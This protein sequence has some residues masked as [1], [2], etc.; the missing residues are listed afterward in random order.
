MSAL[1]GLAA[2]VGN[3]SGT[4]MLQDPRTGTAAES[5]STVSIMP[6]MGDRFFRIDYT[7]VY[8]AKPQEGSPLGGVDKDAGELSGY[9]IDTWQMGHKGMVCAGPAPVDESLSIRGSYIVPPGPDWGWR[10]GTGPGRM[11]CGS[12]TSLSSQTGRKTWRWRPCIRVS[13]R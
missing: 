9:W 1:D 5:H 3:W 13:E 7:W 6:V 2:C 10:V 4:N 12:P 8:Q 11:P